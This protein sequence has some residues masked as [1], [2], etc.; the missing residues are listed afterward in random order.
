LLFQP[1]DSDRSCRQKVVFHFLYITCYF[2]NS[3]TPD[4]AQ[5]K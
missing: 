4:N 1:E 2:N 5:S 3:E